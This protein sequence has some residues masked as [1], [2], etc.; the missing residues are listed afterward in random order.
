MSP[1]LTAGAASAR[2]AGRGGAAG[3]LLAWIALLVAGLRVLQACGGGVLAGPSLTSPSRWLPWIAGR[4]PATVAFAVLRATGLALGWY[5]LAVTG[6]GLLVRLLALGSGSPARAVAR[7]VQVVT[8]PGVG[9]VLELALGTGVVAAVAVSIPAAPPAAAA[10]A[11]G[12]T[13]VQST[14]MASQL[15]RHGQPGQGATMRR[16]DGSTGPE[17]GRPGPARL[18]PP[19][20]PGPGQE[21]APPAR[22]PASWTVARGES[23]WIIARLSLTEAWGRSPSDAEVARYWTELIDANRNRLRHR[24]NPNLIYAGQELAVPAPPAR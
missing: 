6:L 15:G 21:P 8:P 16:L 13:A 24:H 17:A 3:R 9:R 14:T 20:V 2:A 18:D 23:F 7:L 5:L 4:P 12:P 11:A 19:S 22:A 1:S 10:P